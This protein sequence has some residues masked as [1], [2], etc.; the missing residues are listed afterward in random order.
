[1]ALA[2]DAAERLV[3]IALSK[4]TR[5][6]DVIAA[7]KDLLDRAG[8]LRSRQTNRVNN[9][10]GAFIDRSANG[11]FR[12]CRNAGITTCAERAKQQIA[13]CACEDSLISSALPHEKTLYHSGE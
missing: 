4:R 1:L 8:V 5:D 12:V 10:F 7:A 9:P 11:R 3:K 2:A 13:V 6:S